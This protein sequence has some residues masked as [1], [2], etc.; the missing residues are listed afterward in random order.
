MQNSAISAIAL[1]S[2]ILGYYKTSRNH[3]LPKFYPQ[4]VELFYVLPIVYNEDAMKAF[5]SSNQL[6]TALISDDT[7]SL[8]LQERANK[9]TTQT[10]DALNLAFSKHILVYNS[11][12]KS[13]DLA[14]GFR[15]K[16]LPLNLVM[17]SSENRIKRIQD[18]AYKLGT[19][20][21]KTNIK[22]LQLKLNIRF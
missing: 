4:L 17:N 7:I 21:A 19:I 8:D 15:T 6:Y 16:R 9:M 22:N 2:F 1:H 11:A 18:S 5:G 12:D 14:D 3:D 13:I 20:F 10:F